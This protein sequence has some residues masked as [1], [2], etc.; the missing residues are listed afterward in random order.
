MLSGFLLWYKHFILG[1]EIYIELLWV[2]LNNITYINPEK[3][4]QDG[5]DES[6]KQ[7]SVP[8]NTISIGQVSKL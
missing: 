3:D 5:L 4:T 7:K 2:I 6:T 8:L 1:Y